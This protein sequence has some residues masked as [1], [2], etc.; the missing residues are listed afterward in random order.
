MRCMRCACEVTFGWM[1]VVSSRVNPHTGEM[2]TRLLC[3]KCA[4]IVEGR[5]APARSEDGSLSV[6]DVGAALLGERGM[7][8]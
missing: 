4:A 7:T 6:K 5:Q 1:E 2:V 8:L 3:E